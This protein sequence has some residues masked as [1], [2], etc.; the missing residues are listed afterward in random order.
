MNPFTETWVG[1]RPEPRIP[2][3]QSRVGFVKIPRRLARRAEREADEL[4]ARC[5]TKPSETG[6][7]GGTPNLPKNQVPPTPQGDPQPTAQ[8]NFTDPDSRLMKRDGTYLQGYNCQCAV[9]DK[10]QIVVA[11]VVTSQAP[12][13]EHFP[14]L[15]SSVRENAGRLPRRVTADAGYMSEESAAFC[16]A[17]AAAHPTPP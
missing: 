10:C 14:P 2:N 1:G 11:E 12:D 5:S 16:D 4:V 17:H 3:I 7:Q 13:Q 6:G 8:R 9:D 15:M